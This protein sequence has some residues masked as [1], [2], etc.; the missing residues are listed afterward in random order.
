MKYYSACFSSTP[1][2]HSLHTL[3]STEDNPKT[4]N[5]WRIL[6]TAYKS[7]YWNKTRKISGKAVHGAAG[8]PKGSRSSVLSTDSSELS[9]AACHASGDGLMAM[10]IVA[11]D[12]LRTTHPM[13]GA[14]SSSQWNWT[15]CC[16][17]HWQRSVTGQLESPEAIREKSSGGWDI[18]SILFLQHCVQ[19]GAVNHYFICILRLY[20]LFIWD[21]LMT[22]NLEK[23]VLFLWPSP[24]KLTCISEIELRCT[25]RLFCFFTFVFLI[26]SPHS[27]N[28]LSNPSLSFT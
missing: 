22:P 6:A 1:A 26:F 17:R 23:P 3:W 5:Y 20:S 14:W 2:R 7:T 13:Q 11:K 9:A 10:C 19:M 25:M 12:G 8:T 18:G 21:L 24:W 28:S 4:I 27:F 15:L 16:Q